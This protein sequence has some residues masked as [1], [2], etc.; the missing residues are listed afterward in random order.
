MAKLAPGVLLKLL[1]GTNTG[2]NPTG[3]RCSSLLQVADV[4]PAHLDHDTLPP[5]HGFFLKVSDSS[6]SVYAS[7]PPGPG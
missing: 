2:T 6:H 1:D 4:V 7:L 3:E 5:H